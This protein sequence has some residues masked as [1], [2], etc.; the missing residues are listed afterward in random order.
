MSISA[1]TKTSD[2]VLWMLSVAYSVQAYVFPLTGGNVFALYITQFLF[3]AVFAFLY[4]AGTIP[5]G[6]VFKKNMIC[7]A[8][9]S[10]FLVLTIIVNQRSYT[11]NQET[12]VIIKLIGF[13]VTW[14][15]FS[16]LASNVDVAHFFRRIAL[17][18]LPILTYVVIM[19]Y[20]NAL[21][22]RAVPF[23]LQPNWWGEL[24]V[25]FAV[26]SAGFKEFKHRLTLYAVAAIVIFIVQS[27]SAWLALGVIGL[28]EFGR[29]SE[30]SPVSMRLKLMGIIIFTAVL[31]IATP[32]IRLFIVNKILFLNN[33]Y[34]G[35]GTGLTGRISGWLDAISAGFRSPF[36]GTGFSTYLFVHNGYLQ[37]LVETGVLFFSAICLWI[38]IKIGCLLRRCDWIQL[39]AV[40]APAAFIFVEP[41]MFNLNMDSMFFW[42]GMLHWNNNKM[43][44]KN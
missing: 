30:T 36:F 31:C 29:L 40:A 11:N 39:T 8:S 42:L 3:A 44:H 32:I 4:I 19:H 15:I 13:S 21:K 17:C 43:S 5:G 28:I 7:I 35:L 6:K 12:F 14:A 2:A 10:G 27:R 37:M 9:V 33:P 26:A 1:R 24:T 16:W 41:R 20:N 25:A 34:R 22:S 38:I 18:L 23:G